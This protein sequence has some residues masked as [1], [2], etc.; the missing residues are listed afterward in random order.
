[1][2]YPLS[3]E[4]IPTLNLNSKKPHKSWVQWKMGHGNFQNAF[5]SKFGYL[6]TSMIVGENGTSQISSFI[7]KLPWKDTESHTQI[8]TAVLSFAETQ[9]SFRCSYGGSKI[10]T[11]SLHLSFFPL[12][13]VPIMEQT[14]NSLRGHH[15][16]TCC[17]QWAKPWKIHVHG[18]GASKTNFLRS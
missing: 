8:R 2:K 10:I 13:N 9:T 3:F 14:Y 18:K 7:S 17:W 5:S 16:D 12:P 15:H 4:K 6:C 11:Q 1:M